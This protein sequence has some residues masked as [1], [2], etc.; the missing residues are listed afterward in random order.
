MADWMEELGRLAELR[1]KGLLSDEEFEI[2][3]QETINVSSTE[4]TRLS[5]DHQK[6]KNEI[7][8]SWSSN[9]P[10]P[11]ES[12][13]KK[14]RDQPPPPSNQP[15]SPS[16]EKQPLESKYRRPKWVWIAAFVG[17]LS[18][19]QQISMNTYR[20]GESVAILIDLGIFPFLFY[21]IAELIARSRWKSKNK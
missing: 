12:R 19:L 14:L 17:F 6:L 10:P 4:E 21:L 15:L 2:K 3:R 20:D 16:P 1:D 11:S 8:N 13:N 7:I 18:S 5:K 9:K